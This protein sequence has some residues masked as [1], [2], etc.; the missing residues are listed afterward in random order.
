M[1]IFCTICAIILFLCGL[2]KTMSGYGIGTGLAGMFLAACWVL[3]L[4]TS[5]LDPVLAYFPV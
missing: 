2:G 1:I 4:Y 5:M 3:Y